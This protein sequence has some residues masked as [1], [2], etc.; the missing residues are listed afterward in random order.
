MNRTAHHTVAEWNAHHT[1]AHSPGE[2]TP[3]RRLANS[4]KALA[5]KKERCPASSLLC[6]RR[7]EKCS[8]SRV[9]CFVKPDICARKTRT[10]LSRTPYGGSYLAYMIE[11]H[12]IRWLSG[13]HAIRRFIRRGNA[14]HN[15]GSIRREGVNARHNGG[16]CSSV[17]DQRLEIPGSTGRPTHGPALA[18]YRKHWH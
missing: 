15:G 11:Q 6:L 3:Q 7:N 17:M 1:A 8:A 16:P 4:M 14:R 13:T 10:T 18:D 9:L 5:G 2:R 12:T